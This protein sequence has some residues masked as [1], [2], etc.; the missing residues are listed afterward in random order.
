MAVGTGWIGDWE[1]LRY[2]LETF[3]A[4]RDELGRYV[5]RGSIVSYMGAGQ[6]FVVGA[7]AEY[8]VTLGQVEHWRSLPH[9]LGQ[10]SYGLAVTVIG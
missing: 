8:R 4:D 5:V 10:T 6:E 9:A 7:D 1:Q 2:V 3:N